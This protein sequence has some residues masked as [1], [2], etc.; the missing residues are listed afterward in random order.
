MVLALMVLVGIHPLFSHISKADEPANRVRTTAAIKNQDQLGAQLKSI[1]AQYPNVTTGVAVI[2]LTNNDELGPLATYGQSS[3]FVAGSTTK[4]L[5]AVDYLQQVEAGT[6]SL[7]DQLGPATAGW[8]LQQMIQDSND[9]SWMAFITLLGKS[10]MQAWAQKH[11]YTSYDPTGNMISPGDEAALLERLYKG[12]LLNTADTQLVLS[13]MQNTNDQ[14]L[15][16][17]AVPKG[18]TVYN[19]YGELLSEDDNGYGNI[20]HDAAI[21]LD[22]GHNFVLTIYTNRV[23]ELDIASRQD[24][25]HKITKAVLAAETN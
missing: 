6:Y 4:I 9:D 1:F 8:Q 18:V 17:A 5:C 7:N 23:D 24:L 12:E 22:H 13:Y 11:G 10:Q 2:N 19:K 14:T 3:A 16:P 21:I 25:M 15:I 20:V